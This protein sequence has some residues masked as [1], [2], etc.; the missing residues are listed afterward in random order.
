MAIDFPNTPS[1]GQTFT[2]GDRTWSYDGTK[3]NTVSTGN[4]GVRVFANAANRDT[5]IPAPTEGMYSYQQDSNDTTFYNGSAWETTR[6]SDVAGKNKIINGGF[7]FWQRGTSI[8]C[9][10]AA[11]Y[12]ADRWKLW[13][14]ALAA[15]ATVYQITSPIVA[16]FKFAAR[17]QR[18]S[19][20]ASNQEIFFC[21][22]LETNTSLMLS[23]TTVTISGYFRAGANFSGVSN[24]IRF[25]LMTGAGTDQT[26]INGYTSQ[27]PIVDAY[28]NMSTSTQRFSYTAV[29]P[30]NVTQ[31]GVL[32][33]YVPTGTAGANDFIDIDGVQLEAGSVATPF[34][35]AGGTLQGELAACQR[36]YWALSATVIYT[37]G[38]G[39]GQYRVPIYFPI[40]MRSAP[41]V[42]A[43]QVGGGTQTIEFVSTNTAQ[44]GSTAQTYISAL[45]ASAEL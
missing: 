1:V 3:W 17:V 34:S 39:G 23:G 42:T 2:V 9:G 32:I 28:P 13:R 24:Q 7:D 8:A 38:A 11:P 21:Q 35:R 30:A 36:Y 45:T 16:G 43:T 6:I 37:Y 31:L 4:S 22:D 27:T 40:S 10:T 25:R 12:T 20:N 44:I 18:D 15:G 26:I 41:T 14:N 29:I 33:S 19:G 5:A